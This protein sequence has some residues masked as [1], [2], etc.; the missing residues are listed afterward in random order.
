MCAILDNDRISEV[1]GSK[2]TR[3]G[4]AFRNW[5]DSGKGQLVVG[6]KLR[7]ELSRNREFKDWLQQ[8]LLGGRARSV[9][10]EEVEKRT[11]V[12][13]QSGVCISDDPHNIALAQLSRARLLYTNDDDL[14]QDFKNKALVDDPRGKIYSTRYDEDFQE[15]HRRLLS[16]KK[17]CIGR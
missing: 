16:E 14:M 3:A 2:C 15:R 17:L 6:G 10:D 4:V 11:A 5:I 7:R 12:L 1:F 9:S 13:K 8:A